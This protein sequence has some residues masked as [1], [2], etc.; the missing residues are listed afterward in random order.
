MSSTAYDN[1]FIAEALPAFIS[2]AHEQIESL[3]QLLLQLEDAP[4]DR[5]IGNGKRK[6]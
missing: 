5:V 2:E 1:S 4:G 3:E 6:L